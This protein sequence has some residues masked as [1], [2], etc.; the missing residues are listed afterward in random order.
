MEFFPKKP[1]LNPKA[2]LITAC[3]SSDGV[4]Y[5]NGVEQSVTRGRRYGTKDCPRV[6]L[7]VNSDQKEVQLDMLQQDNE[8][9]LE[10]TLDELKAEMCVAVCF[11]PSP[12]DQPSTIQLVGSSCERVAKTETRTTMDLWDDS[13]KQGVNDKPKEAIGKGELFGSS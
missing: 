1:P 8:P 9:I 13:N 7:D 11:G 4:V 12:P 5:R 3:R 2:Q 6:S 10:V